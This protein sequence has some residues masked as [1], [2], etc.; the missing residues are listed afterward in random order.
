MPYRTHC[1][2]GEHLENETAKPENRRD[3]CSVACV[4]VAHPELK[5]ALVAQRKDRIE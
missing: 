1:P 2:C 4:L 5:V 3:F